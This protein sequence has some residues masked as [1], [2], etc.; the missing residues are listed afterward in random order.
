MDARNIANL[1]RRHGR[2]VVLRRQLPTTPVSFATVVVQGLER[3]FGV[4]E[5]AGAIVQGDHQVIVLEEELAAA[6][7]PLPVQHNDLVVIGPIVTDG[8]W[9][10]GSGRPLTIQDPGPRAGVGFWIQA[11][12]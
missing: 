2:P 8:V 7:Y 3:A 1:M 6:G 10:R 12:G 11:R 9:Q 4:H 5:L